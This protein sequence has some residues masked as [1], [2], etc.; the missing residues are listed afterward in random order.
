MCPTSCRL[1]EC[2][3][4]EE[5]GAGTGPYM[6]RGD[7][8]ELDLKKIKL[9]NYATTDKLKLDT[10]LAFFH[11]RK[12]TFLRGCAVLGWYFYFPN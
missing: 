6:V 11:V 4:A 3:W 8:G 12:P 7:T 10:I 1:C 5:G 2:P 9:S